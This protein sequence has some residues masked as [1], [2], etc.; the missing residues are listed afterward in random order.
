MKEPK[1]T[2]MNPRIMGSSGLYPLSFLFDSYVNECL[3]NDNKLASAVII[4]SK[5]NF[6]AVPPQA[7]SSSVS[8]ALAFK[9]DGVKVPFNAKILSKYLD[10]NP[11]DFAEYK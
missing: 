1:I 3:L 9:V 10:A 6:K 8:K 5:L 4:A 11:Q 7:K 2:D